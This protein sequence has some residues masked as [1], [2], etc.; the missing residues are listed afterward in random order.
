[1]A[2]M[3]LFPFRRIAMW[4]VHNVPLGRFAPTVLG[5]AIGRRGKRGKRVR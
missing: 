2:N 3:L 1:M 4:M 5:F